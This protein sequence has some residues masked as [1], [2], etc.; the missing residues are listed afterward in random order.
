MVGFFDYMTVL[1]AERIIVLTAGGMGNQNAVSDFHGFYGAD[2]SNSLAEVGGKLFK[3]GSPIPAGMPSIRHS[4]TPPE[5]SFS[6]ISP[7]K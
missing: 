1:A 6:C 2:G 4:M 3:T 5:E 7:L